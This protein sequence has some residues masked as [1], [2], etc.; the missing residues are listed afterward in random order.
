MRAS[1][2]ARCSLDALPRFWL[3][4]AST[5]GVA[6]ADAFMCH[7]GHAVAAALRTV[8]ETAEAARS[9]L[10][11]TRASLHAAIDLRCDALEREIMTAERAKIA[12]LEREL[13]SVDSVLERWRADCGSM[14]E[15][16]AAVPDVELAGKQAALTARMGD[17]ESLLQAL[18]TAPLEPP[19]VDLAGDASQLLHAISKFGHVVSPRAITASSLTPEGLPPYAV[20]GEAVEIRLGLGADHSDQ[21]SEELEVSLGR[22]HNML[23]VEAEYAFGDAAAVRIK[24]IVST[25]VSQRSLVVTLPLPVRPAPVGRISL[26]APPG[27]RKSACDWGANRF[28]YRLCFGCTRAR[29]NRPD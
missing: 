21:T 15:T 27:Y 17:L 24:A 19:V 1:L 5:R 16:L 10:Q 9:Q 4:E 25:N 8:P 2:N 29:C 26:P 18:P 7:I 14:R 11:S 13:V 20:W 12:A 23:R 28:S 22:L 3:L 6:S